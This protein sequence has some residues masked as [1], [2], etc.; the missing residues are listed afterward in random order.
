MIKNIIGIASCKGGVGKSTL[1]VNIA[2]T[3]SKFFKKN[4]GLLDADI[5]GPSHP[6]L[7]GI[8]K[9]KIIQNNDLITPEKKYEILSMSIGYFL[10]EDS[11]ILLRGPMISNTINYIIKKTNW[12]ELD[13]LIIDF[14]PGTGDVY[15]TLLRDFKFNGIFLITIPH[16]ISTIDVKKSIIMLK[17]LNINILGLIENMK[18]Y[19]CK[20][21][22]EKNELYGEDNSVGELI[23]EFNI[24][25]KY[26]LNFDLKISESC[27]KG[28]PIAY[29]LIDTPTINLLK[30]IC[31]D[32]I[33]KI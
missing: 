11:S 10:K 9:K 6:N 13:Y 30:D 23:K 28:V 5:Y 33:K 16:I 31:S 20:N 21:C 14:P 2:I 18:Y 17:K 15:L 12:G 7:L 29:N 32:L 8:D 26:S 22:N 27:I 24:K 3:L 1:A 4:V 25:K 19:T